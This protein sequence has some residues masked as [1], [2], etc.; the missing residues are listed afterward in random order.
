MTTQ[1]RERFNIA[2]CLICTL[3]ESMKACQVCPFREGLKL[4]QTKEE[5]IK[6]DGN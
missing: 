5:E 1:E 6:S 2:C 3:A 4:K